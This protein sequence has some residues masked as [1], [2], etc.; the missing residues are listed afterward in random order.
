MA[1]G[2]VRAA[3]DRAPATCRAADEQ[4]MNKSAVIDYMTKPSCNWLE[5]ER[6]SRTAK[7]SGVWN[8]WGTMEA[9]C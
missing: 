1:N 9:G 4:P 3:A 5:A 7:R 2:N 6:Y 8:Q